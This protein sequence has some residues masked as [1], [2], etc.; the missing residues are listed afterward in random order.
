MLFPEIRLSFD[1]DD[2][3]SVV[4]M[5]DG[6]Y[7]LVG[8]FG[9]EEDGSWYQ[10]QV[11]QDMYTVSVYDRDGNDMTGVVENDEWVEVPIQQGDEV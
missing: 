11:D 7:V 8:T 3:E 9:E 2:N 5:A 4:K 6:S 10:L 1:R